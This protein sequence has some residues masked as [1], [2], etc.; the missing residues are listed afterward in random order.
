[1]K[2]SVDY[3][4]VPLTHIKNQSPTTG[5]VPQIMQIVR[6]MPIYKSG[7]KHNFINYIPINILPV[8]LKNTRKR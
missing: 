3:I 1:M 2:E 5:I 4:L 6:G 8:F 7:D